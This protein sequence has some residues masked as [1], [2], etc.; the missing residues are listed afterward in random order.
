MLSVYRFSISFLILHYFKF[1]AAK[2]I[3]YP[4]CFLK[5]VVIFRYYFVNG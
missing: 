3:N 4:I 1:D 5:Q 2:I